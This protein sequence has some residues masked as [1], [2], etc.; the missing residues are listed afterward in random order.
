MVLLKRGD[1]IASGSKDHNINIWKLLFD[2][3]DVCTGIQLEIQ[4]VDNCEIYCLN[5]LGNNDKILISGGS[6]KMAKVW[7]IETGEYINLEENL[8]PIS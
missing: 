2:K 3:N 6:D 8:T 1:M 4:L 7:N 5:S